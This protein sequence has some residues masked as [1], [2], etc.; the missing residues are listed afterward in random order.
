MSDFYTD[1]LEQS[2]ANEKAVGESPRFTRSKDLK[3]VRTPQDFKA[4]LMIAPE[5]G[6]TTGGSC[7]MRAEIP[8]GWHTGKH[9]HGE[10]A[11]YV[12][13]GDGFMILDDKRYD[14]HPGTIIHVPYR[15]THQLFNAGN[16]PVGYI[17]GLAWHLE[18]AV[19]MGKLEQLEVCGENDPKAMAA[20]PKEES[21]YWPEDGR[22]ISM[23]HSQHVK[24]DESKHG[25]TYFL[26]G[27]SGKD[28]GFKA[29][30][31]AISS[32][33]VDL[34]HTKSHSHAHPEA[35]LYALE[36][37]GYSEIGGK[38]YDWNQGDA[39]HVPPGMLHHQH[40]NPFDRD[41]KELRFEFGVRYWFVDQ[42]KGYV[43]VDK[44]LKATTHLID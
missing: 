16:V 9:L 36:G 13:S 20:M 28:N 23:H 10:E 6:F 18:A 11:I 40:F 2:K 26:M 27:R 29:T 44:H 15:S 30:G 22:R 24:S 33:F 19:Y 8:V 32:I 31:V 12:E 42:W 17:S 38:R 25:A 39:I 41:M 34:P 37:D 43:T 5:L 7:M 21:Q 35:Y 14:F 1:W 4:A 3:W